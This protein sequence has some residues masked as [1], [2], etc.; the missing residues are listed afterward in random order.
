MQFGEGKAMR[1]KGIVV[2]LYLR[3]VC[4]LHFIYHVSVC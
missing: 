1:A 2:K 3:N 4:Q